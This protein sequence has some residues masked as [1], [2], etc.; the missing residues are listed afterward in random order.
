MQEPKTRKT[1]WPNRSFFWDTWLTEKRMEQISDWLGTLTPEQK[2][3]LKDILCDYRSDIM[4][5][6][7]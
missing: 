6:C 1:V 2:D 5:Q 7:V 4:R 3:M